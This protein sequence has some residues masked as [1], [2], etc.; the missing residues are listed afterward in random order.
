MEIKEQIEALRKELREHNYRYYALSEPVISDYEFDMKLKVLQELEAAHPE[1]FDPTSPTQRVGGGITKNFETIVHDHRMYS[2]DNSYSREEVQDWEKRI[3]RI[4]GVATVSYTCELKYDGASINLTYEGGQLLQAVTR[5][6]GIQGDEVTTNIKTIRSIPLQLNGAPMG[7][8]QVRGEIIL[9]L[10]G[11]AKMNEERVKAGEDPYMNP[12]NTAAGSIKLQDS[13]L[14]AERPLE[15]LAYS[16][17]GNDLGIASQY[18][19]LQ[20]AR[21]WG[22]K[23][24]PEARLCKSI[25]EVMAYI[26]KWDE[27]RH[28]LPYETDGVVI[29]V[30]NLQQQDEL[31]FT[32]KAPRWALA[33]KFQMR[34]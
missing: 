21:K 24:P 19:L 6:D 3:H 22:F 23:V 7:R 30:N 32:A 15:C 10:D 25:D 31:G 28:A 12:R 5:G 16:M 18:D 4:L 17:K 34:I 8:F 20:A 11:F 9:P 13:S 27:E 33:Y 26:D 1:Y 2:L 14:V 29:K